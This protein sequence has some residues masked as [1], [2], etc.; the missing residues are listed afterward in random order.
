MIYVCI[1][2]SLT[3]YVFSFIVTDTLIWIGQKFH[4]LDT[5]HGAL[6]IWLSYVT[7]L[8]IKTLINMDDTFV[9]DSV[10]S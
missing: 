9:S 6:T 7:H 2:Y 8:I 3:T 10:T 1:Y 5:R 4:Y